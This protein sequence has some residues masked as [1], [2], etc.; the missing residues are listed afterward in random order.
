[1]YVRNKQGM[2]LSY[3]RETYELQANHRT[4]RKTQGL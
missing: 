4:R 3:A 2:L 1:M